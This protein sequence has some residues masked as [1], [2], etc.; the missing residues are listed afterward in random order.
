MKIKGSILIL[1]LIVLLLP[2]CRDTQTQ[3]P[4]SSSA[5]LSQTAGTITVSLDSVTVAPGERCEVAIRASE[6]A[7][8]AAT[9]LEIRFD[10]SKLTYESF[11]AGSDYQSGYSLGQ[12]AEEGLIK[13]AL[14]TVNPPEDAAVIGTI[15]FTAAQTAVGSVPLELTYTSCCDYDVKPLQPVCV[16]GEVQV[17]K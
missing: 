16:N 17:E 4:S 11:T 6:N 15:A 7:G 10:A 9:D 13:V 3:T 8:I 5:D 12:L 1:C 2:G 14:V